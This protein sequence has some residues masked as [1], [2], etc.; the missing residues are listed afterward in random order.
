M[1]KREQ[2]IKLKN[3]GMKQKDIA[4][5]LGLAISTISYYLNIDKR[6]E[7]FKKYWNNLSKEK[8]SI[9]YKRRSPYI[10]E[11]MRK[12]YKND[13]NYRENKIINSQKNY[14]IKIKKLKIGNKYDKRNY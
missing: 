4:E 7:S 6:K 5:Q 9:I 8:K 14:Q 13:E 10:K 1:N 11:W 12:K 3:S 2:I